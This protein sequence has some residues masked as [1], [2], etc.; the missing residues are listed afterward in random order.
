M[1]YELAKKLKDS[2]FPQEYRKSEIAMDWVYNSNG[3]LLMLHDDNDTYWWLGQDYTITFTEELLKMEYIKCPTLSELIEALGKD[4]RSLN[5]IYIPP[6]ELTWFVY[7][8]NRPNELNIDACIV[9]QGS[10]PE[11]AVANLWLELNIK[12]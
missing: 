3:T 6:A 8:S 11:E 7:S 4:F 9:K 2:G 5:R 1:T 10:T 12:L